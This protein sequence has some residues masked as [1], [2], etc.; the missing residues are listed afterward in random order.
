MC[1]RVIQASGP[2][3]LSLGLVDGMEGRRDPFGNMPPRYNGAPGQE[4]WVI[5]QEAAAGGRSLDLLRWGLIPHFLADKPKPPPINARAESAAQKPLFRQAYAKR[6]CIVPVDGFFEWKTVAGGARQPFAFAMKHRAPFGLAG[7]WENWRDP[8]TGDWI[9]TFCILTTQANALMRPVH[10]RMP[11]ILRPTDYEPWLAAGGVDP[12]T[13]APYPD[14]PMTL[15][16]VST[17]V[18]APRNDDPGVIEPMIQADTA[19]PPDGNS[20]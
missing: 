5:R 10:D 20:A 11:V 16:P 4:L 6:R 19:A 15:W 9:R 18:N 12:E 14:E 7:L 3:R 13:L 17:R 1:G 8:K 2:E